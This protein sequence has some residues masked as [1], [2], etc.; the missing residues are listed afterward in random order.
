VFLLYYR[1][2]FKC[3]S[4][5]GFQGIGPQELYLG[6]ICS[7]NSGTRQ[8]EFI[9]T[10]GFYHEQARPDRDNHI[11]IKW[12]NIKTDSELFVNG[13]I[14]ILN[15]RGISYDSTHILS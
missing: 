1:P 12:D 5:I 14:N 15:P 9:H 8:H 6:A 2:P 3:F 10:L 13:K 4:R 11:I 7:A